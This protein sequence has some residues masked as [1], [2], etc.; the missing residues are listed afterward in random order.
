[1][2]VHAAPVTRSTVV[3]AIDVGKNE[4][5]V[6]VTDAARTKLLKPQLGC[7]MTGSSV[8]KVVD[9]I[10]RLLPPDAEVKIGI[11][12]AGHYHRPLLTADCWPAGWELLELNPGHVTEQR[13]VL[14][15]RTIKTDAVDL[16]AMSELLLAGRGL[17]VRARDSVLTELTAWSAHRTGRVLIRTATKNRLLGQLDRS[18][19]G[20]TLAL[21]DVLG[22]KVGRLIAAEFADPARLAAL[23]RTR[24]IRFGAARGL[25]I[26][27]STA[28]KLVA[29]AKDAMPMPDAAVARA[30]LAADLALLGDLDAQID[31]ATAELTRLVPRSPFKTLLTVKGWG[32]VRAGNYGGALGDPARFATARQVYRTAGLNP[33]QY[34]SAGKRRDSAIS[35][36]GSVELRRAL[37]DLG[38]GLWLNDPAAKRHATAL[39]A[40]GKNGRIIACAMAHRANRI[41]FALVRDQADYDSTR[42]IPED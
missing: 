35:R 25:Q 11:E 4:F 19:P 20:L 16:E 14:G 21:P 18:F 30:V 15:K 38:L 10:H 31:A 8:R 24:F 3:V 1:M 6:S 36:E 37:I 29:A 12:A 9:T 28:D 2:V 26:R 17:P 5:A 13:R 23:G 41:A 22:T 32:A 39:R 33:I 27:R 40:R 7:P 34:E 42:W